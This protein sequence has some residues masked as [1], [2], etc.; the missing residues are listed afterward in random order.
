MREV[1]VGH[2][3]AGRELRSCRGDSPAHIGTVPRF[4]IGGRVRGFFRAAPVRKLGAR[5]EGAGRHRACFRWSG[6]SLLQGVAEYGA[7]FSRQNLFHMIR[8]V[9]A[10]PEQA[11]LSVLAQHLGWSHFKETL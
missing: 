10:W 9:E 3:V 11:Q 7:G 5:C 4:R 6:A 1:P 2:G 8:F